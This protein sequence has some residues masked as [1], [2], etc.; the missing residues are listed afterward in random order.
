MRYGIPAVLLGWLLTFVLF[1][2]FL[3]VGSGLL[4]GPETAAMSW[5]IFPLALFYGL[6][7]AVVVGL[8]FAMLVAW[9]LRKVRKQ[10]LHVAAHALA[11]GAVACLAVTALGNWS[12]WRQSFPIG[13]IAAASAAIGRAAVIKLVARRNNL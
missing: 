4:G 12:D 5:V 6:P 9:P 3:V 13:L 2:L 7:V 8:P 11:T 1:C 10:W